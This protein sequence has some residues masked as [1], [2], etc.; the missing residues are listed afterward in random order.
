MFVEGE[1]PPPPRPAVGPRLGAG[2]LAGAGFAPTANAGFFLFGGLAFPSWSIDVEGRLDLPATEET[3][4]F[5]VRTALRLAQV[6]VCTRK[7]PAF[8]CAIA[9]GGVLAASSGNENDAKSDTFFHGHVGVRVGI[10]SQVVGPLALRV[11]FD[12]LL[13]VTRATIEVGGNEAWITPPVGFAF[14]AGPTLRF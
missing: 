3:R 9:G 2:V 10:E 14:G 13:P 11:A 5:T 1:E 7:G 4:D 8:G 12:V 6:V